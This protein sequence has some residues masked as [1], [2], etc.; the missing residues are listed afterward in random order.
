[1]MKKQNTQSPTALRFHLTFRGKTFIALSFLASVLL[2]VIAL[3]GIVG[4]V[5]GAR[6][7]GVFTQG[8]VV[9][10][11]VGDGSAGLASSAT[12]VFL[13]EYTTGGILVQSIPFPTTV[14]GTNKR[15]TASGTATSEGLM[16]LS[17]DGR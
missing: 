11:R 1:M 8:N 12:A 9:V 5:P 13:D 4:V 3:T 7:A 10:Y 17:S 16:T 15:L 14:N 6:A 2:G